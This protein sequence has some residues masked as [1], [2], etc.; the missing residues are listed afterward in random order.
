M[1]VKATVVY[2]LKDYYLLEEFKMYLISLSGDLRTLPLILR[3]L[4]SIQILAQVCGVPV[5]R[6]SGGRLA[7]TLV[8]GLHKVK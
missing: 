3:M 7:T 8:A 2:L 4:L 1:K 6:R 5:G